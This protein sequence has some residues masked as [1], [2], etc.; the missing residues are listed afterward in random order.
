MCD[1]PKRLQQMLLALQRYDLKVLFRKGSELYVADTLSRAYLTGPVLPRD[2]FDEQFEQIH[3]AEHV[4]NVSDER[5]RQVLEHILS[6]DLN[7]SYPNWL[8]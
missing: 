6:A 7:I 1:A 4:C 3:A 8:A 5:M 2:G